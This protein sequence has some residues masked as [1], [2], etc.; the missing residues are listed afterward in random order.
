MAILRQQNLLRPS[1]TLS[2]RK[3]GDAAPHEYA[4]QDS[5][6]QDT[7][8]LQEILR[9]SDI[10]IYVLRIRKQ[11]RSRHA[12]RDTRHP[13]SFTVEVLRF[14]LPRCVP[15]CNGKHRRNDEERQQ[16]QRARHP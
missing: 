2:E 5:A 1:L 13:I 11:E 4:K 3:H 6:K 16:L 10:G 14:P 7:R 9:G 8:Q 12:R 15:D